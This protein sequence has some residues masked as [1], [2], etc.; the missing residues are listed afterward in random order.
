M[1]STK[2]TDRELFNELQIVKGK[3]ILKGTKQKTEESNGDGEENWDSLRYY[4]GASTHLSEWVTGSGRSSGE[5]VDSASRIVRRIGARTCRADTVR[6]R[7]TASTVRS[8][9]Q[10]KLR[11][12][13]VRSRV[14]ALSRQTHQPLFSERILRAAKSCAAWT[15][16]HRA[17]VA[18]A[19]AKTDRRLEPGSAA[20]RF[21]RS[22]RRA[23]RI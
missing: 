17:P 16:V 15:A 18:V 20:H 14:G 3:G 23:L 9:V 8:S 6:W 22:T 12:E 2:A 7:R 10:A 11:T 5:V 1:Y 13:Q 4:A 19:R 21:D